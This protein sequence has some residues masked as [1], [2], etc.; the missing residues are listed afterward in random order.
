VVLERKMNKN[1]AEKVYFSARIFC[2]L[3]FFLVFFKD[4]SIPLACNSK[5]KF[6]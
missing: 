1:W 2:V 3:Q 4:F 5:I 6:A